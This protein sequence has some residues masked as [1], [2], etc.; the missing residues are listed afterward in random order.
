MYTGFESLSSLTSN[1]LIIFCRRN[2][3]NWYWWMRS[4]PLSQWRYMHWWPQQLYLWM[5]WGIHGI[6]LWG[7]VWCLCI[8]PLPKF[9]FMYRKTWTTKFLLRMYTRCVPL[10]MRSRRVEIICYSFDCVLKS[11]SSEWYLQYIL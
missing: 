11:T 3:R 9:C 4:E 7:G 8:Q 2:L 6:Q 5:W 10:F 1:F